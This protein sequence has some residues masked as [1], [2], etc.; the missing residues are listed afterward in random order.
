MIYPMKYEKQF[1]SMIYI[2]KFDEIDIIRN[3]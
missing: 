1:V 2:Y 3:A